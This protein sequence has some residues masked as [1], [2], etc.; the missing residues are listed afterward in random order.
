MN[1][2]I[3]TAIAIVTETLIGN[4]EKET[5]NLSTI[6]TVRPLKNPI[7]SRKMLPLALPQSKKKD[8]LKNLKNKEGLQK[9][10]LMF[11]LKKSVKETRLSYCVR[12]DLEK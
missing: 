12:N 2:A 7:F 4:R 6:A 11:A 9:R 5:V 1:A 8:L 10:H 3:G